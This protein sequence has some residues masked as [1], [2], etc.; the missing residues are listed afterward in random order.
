VADLITVE[1]AKTALQISGV[2]EDARLAVLVSAASAAVEK[3]CQRTFL[4]ASYTEY[5]SGTNTQRLALRRRPVSAVTSVKLDS[6]G[7]FGLVAGSFGSTTTLTAGVDYSLDVD[8]GSAVSSSGVLFRINGVWPMIARA[9]VPHRV[10]VEVSPAFG[11]L[12]VA[13]TAGFAA[14]PE[15]VKYAAAM[16]VQQMRISLRHG[17]MLQSETIGDYAYRLADGLVMGRGR[18][19]ADVRHVLAPYRETGW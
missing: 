12:L 16:V 2:T 13:Y 11:N 19:M 7:Q 9:G 6:N 8:Q 10:N 5:Y 3:Y 15:D 4:S 14:V 17:G 18:E 1:Y